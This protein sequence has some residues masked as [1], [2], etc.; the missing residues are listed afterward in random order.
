MRRVH[1]FFQLMVGCG[2]T[3]AA[4]SLLTGALWWKGGR[5]LPQAPWFLKLVVAA[6]PLGLI[7]MESGWMV[8]ETGRQPWIVWQVMR[9]ADAVTPTTGLA[10]SF[11][12]IVAVYL[13][14]SV[15]TGVLLW[16]QITAPPKEAAT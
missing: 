4:L 3:L 13:L 12:S 7:A 6:S 9:T 5:V 1:L 15:A 14:L 2:V 8:T 11:W 10:L 16:R